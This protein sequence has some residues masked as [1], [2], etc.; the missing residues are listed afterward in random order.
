LLEC[1]I[2]TRIR[3]VIDGGYSTV[4]AGA[5]TA[6]IQ[7]DSECFA[8]AQSV[9]GNATNFSYASAPN[10]SLPIACSVAAANFGAVDVHFNPSSVAAAAG[11]GEGVKVLRGQMASLV[12]LD[13]EMDLATAMVTLTLK[14]PSAVWFGVGFNAS[15]MA[16]NPWA[17]IVDGNG[18]ITE[19]SLLTQNPGTLL[20]KSSVEVVSSSVTD[21][22]RTVVLR[23]AAN[24]EY[25]TFRP[26]E[27][28]RLPMINAI[29]AQP[30]LS[31]HVKRMPT[32]LS[33]LPVGSAGVCVCAF[34]PA[35]FGEAHGTLVYAPVDQPGEAGSGTLVFPNKC[36]PAPASDLLAQQNPTCD[37][38]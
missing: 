16:D 35:P 23:R 3:K 10:R 21:G 26:A 31:Y 18:T 19:R 20:P 36:A 17:I 2:T 8:A 11:C 15:A 9:F 25:F 30:S 13:A 6:L 4:S 27:L 22:L 38:R 28:T 32:T 33:M 29:G 37:I 1:P 12:T 5:C 14:G 7:T 24:H 34:K